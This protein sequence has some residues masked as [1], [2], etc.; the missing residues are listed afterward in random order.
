L[1][2]TRGAGGAHVVRAALESVCY[3][4]RDLVEAMT[5]DGA[6]APTELRVDGGMAANDWMVQYLADILD[7]AV[8]R[9]TILETTA[10]GAAALA[11]MTAGLFG[12]TDDIAATWGRERDFLPSMAPEVRDAA[13]DGWADAVRRV[14]TTQGGAE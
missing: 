5:A 10:W 8:A 9:P 7:T 12:S 13:I 6:T 14:L 11:G 4:T 2:L 3:Q 1:G